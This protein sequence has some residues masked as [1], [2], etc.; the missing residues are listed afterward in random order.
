MRGILP[1]TN[2]LSN[3]EQ[4][5]PSSVN[6]VM[7]YHLILGPDVLLFALPRKMELRATVRAT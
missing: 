2:L 7:D 5:P 6:P 1:R 4:K 3:E